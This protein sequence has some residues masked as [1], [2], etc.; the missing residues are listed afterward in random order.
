MSGGHYGM[1]PRF[2]MNT[3]EMRS[4]SQMPNTRPLSS[5]N[6]TRP[7]TA[8]IRT[9]RVGTTGSSLS[10]RASARPTTPALDNIKNKMPANVHLQFDY[11]ITLTKSMPLNEAIENGLSSIFNAEFCCFWFF[12]PINKK[13]YSPT[14]NLTIDSNTSILSQAFEKNELLNISK[15]V[16][17]PFYDKFVDS[18]FL[19]TLYIPITRPDKEIVA[20]IQL[21][22]HVSHKFTPIDVNNI[23]QFMLKFTN[24]SHFLFDDNFDSSSNDIALSKSK[25]IIPVIIEQLEKH[26]KCRSVELWVNDDEDSYAK[27]DIASNTYISA[28]PGIVKRG[29]ESGSISLNFRNITGARGYFK[30]IDGEKAES[31]LIVPY[32]IGDLPCVICLR[33]KNYYSNSADSNSPN[34]SANYFTYADEIQITHL[35]PLIV[36]CIVSENGNA[37]ENSLASRLKALLEVAEILSGVLDIDVLVPTI[38]ER[39]CSLLHTQRCS[40]FLVDSKRTKLRTTFQSGL[41]K[42]ISIPIN[43]GI[44][45]HSA[46]T[47]NIVNVEDAYTDPRFNQ[48]VDSKTGFKTKTILS[49]PIFNNRGEI[50]GVTEMINREDGEKFDDEDIQMMKAF[51]IFCGISLDNARLYQASIDLTRQLHG[52]ADMANQLNSQNN[53]IRNILEG[54]IQ[55]A[56]GVVSG[57]RATIFMKNEAD[58]NLFN[59]LTIGE[60]ITHGMVFSNIVMKN[61]T[62]RIFSPQEIALLTMSPGSNEDFNSDDLHGQ[63]LDKNYTTS[64]GLARIA[65]TLNISSD[66]NVSTADINFMRNPIDMP[67]TICCFPLIKVDQTF[68]GVLEISCKRRII[69]E[70]IKL[71]DCFAAFASV[72]LEKSELQSIATLG[73]AEVEL[74]KFIS[75]TERTQVG[76]I[77]AKLKIA[78]TESLYKIDFDAAQWEG[79]GY[80]RVLWAIFDTFKLFREFKIANQT[81]FKF[82]DAISNTYNKVPYHNWRHA[83]DVTQFVTYQVKITKLDLKLTKFELFALLISAICHD[84]NH[85]GFTNVFNEKAETP[86]GILFKNQSVMETHHCT[87]TINVISKE[88]NNIFESLDTSKLKEIWNLII[89]LILTTDMAR[90]HTFLTDTNQLLE[91]GPLDMKLPEHRFVTMQLLLKCADISNVSRPFELADKWCDVL[92]EEFFRQGDLEKTS[93]MEYTSPLNDREHLDKPKSQIGFYTFVCLPLYQCAAKAL[94]PLQVNVEQVEANLAVWKAETE[95]KK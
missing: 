65:N 86:L 37:P 30:E 87:I 13:F 69:P 9:I 59:Y 20:L 21:A 27:Y 58:N 79:I 36:K 57:T 22:R 4:I 84:A 44:A 82:L 17:S 38:M 91:K 42:A 90:H 60:R 6:Q 62:H 93:G 61:K 16:A 53:T 43:Q 33:G 32:K 28:Q 85:D 19:P 2:K 23:Q 45:G 95:K 94:P 77:P 76:I 54:I 41:D 39:A 31:I 66:S 34:N 25:T 63:P 46:T 3:N 15:P 56:K 89:N 24:Y 7:T 12:D 83:V 47:G 29:F 50:V 14:K 1:D 52:F 72:S 71:L 75:Q 55:N 74:K 81:F 67:E 80:F 70:D 11:I 10:R 18:E 88:E 8:L 35:T 92:C 68:M 78:R 48:N 5:L 64:S 73:R 26:F 51:N 49:V 40:L